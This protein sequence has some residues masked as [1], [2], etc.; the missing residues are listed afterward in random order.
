MWQ[1]N[2]MP[3]PCKLK[4]VFSYLVLNQTKMPHSTDIPTE[5]GVSQLNTHAVKC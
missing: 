4:H 3:F 1:E 5:A 2:N